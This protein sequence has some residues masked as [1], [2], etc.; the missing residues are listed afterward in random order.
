MVM[1]YTVITWVYIKQKL[2]IYYKTINEEYKINFFDFLGTIGTKIELKSNYFPITSYTKWNLYQY[3]VDCNPEEE[4]IGV[5]KALLH[6]H[7]K[8]LSPYIFDGTMLFSTKKYD[9]KVSI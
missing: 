4:R 3:R 2:L 8:L 6:V 1:Y 7:D 5:K 9:S